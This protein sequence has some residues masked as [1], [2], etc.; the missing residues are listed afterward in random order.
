MFADLERRIDEDLEEIANASA[1]LFPRI[2]VRRDGSGD[3]RDA[4]SREKLRHVGKA[5]DI[6]VAVDFRKAK[7]LREILANLVAIKHFNPRAS[8]LKPPGKRRRYS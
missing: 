7:S 8:R 1:G 6:E 3:D 4:V 5:A 2:R